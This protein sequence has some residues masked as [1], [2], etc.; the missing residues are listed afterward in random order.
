MTKNCL[1]IV[2]FI[3]ANVVNQSLANFQSLSPLNLKKVFD[4]VKPY[5][6]LTNAFYSLKCLELV[7]DKAQNP[8][9]VVC[10][11]FERL[12]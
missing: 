6:D 8:Q 2:C 12:K 9:V 11:Q 7:G 4:S 10:S 5:T 1:L 3:L